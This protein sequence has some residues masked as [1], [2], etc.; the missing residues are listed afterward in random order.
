[1][2]ETTTELNSKH[3]LFVCKILFGLFNRTLWRSYTLEI[4]DSH[5]DISR[6]VRRI[7]KMRIFFIVNVDKGQTIYW[8]T[9]TDSESS[10]LDPCIDDS[11]EILVGRHAKNRVL[12]L[13]IG[14]RVEM[15]FFRVLKT[16]KIK[17]QANSNC[18]TENIKYTRLSS[19]K[20]IGEMPRSHMY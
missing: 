20:F 8:R 4:L 13:D 6:K 15:L 1:M 3:S 19:P 9:N 16:V 17:L 5:Q 18:E 2:L 10:S 7:Y 14:N 11:I 12:I